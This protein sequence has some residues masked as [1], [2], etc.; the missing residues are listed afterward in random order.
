MSNLGGVG[1]PAPVVAGGKVASGW[2]GGRASV[3][4]SLS[5]VCDVRNLTI[6]SGGAAAH[7]GKD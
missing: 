1:L 3:P 7:F 4:G 2:R 5:A 6:G